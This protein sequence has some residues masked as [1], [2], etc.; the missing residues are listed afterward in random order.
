MDQA[1]SRRFHTDKSARSSEDG[2]SQMDASVLLTQIKQRMEEL[3]REKQPETLAEKR[4][5]CQVECDSYNQREGNLPGDSCP[6]CLNKGRVLRPVF[7]K[8]YDDFAA[9]SFRC[10]CMPARLAK[11]RLLLSGIG[12]MLMKCTLDNF[13][14]SL[15]YWQNSMKAD[16]AKFVTMAHSGYWFYIGGDAGSGKS[17]LCAG[18]MQELLALEMACTWM[19]WVD[20]S[21]RAISGWR[22]EY[23][24]ALD[25]WRRAP[26]LII[27]D[28]LKPIK[29]ERNKNNLPKEDS[30]KLAYSIVNY[31]YNNPKLVTIIS[32]EHNLE[33]LVGF[34]KAMASRIEH[35]C[36]PDFVL[37]NG[38]E[39]QRNV[40][41]RYQFKTE[42]QPA[43]GQLQIP[44][45]F[46]D[47]SLAGV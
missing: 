14:T 33:T 40:R 16:A 8:L 2:L 34:D 30:L 39:G 4:V 26:V 32:S 46:I 44:D 45:E 17:H 21:T 43:P 13:D 18:I 29:S 42:K 1:Q 37:D 6:K 5:A 25:P 47:E 35:R 15:D 19:D 38:K 31:R 11:Q 28:F 22:T 9:T 20:D 3:Q 36:G 7:E 41:H 27:D 12:P 23:D 10:N 24:A